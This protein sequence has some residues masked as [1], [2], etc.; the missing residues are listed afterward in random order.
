MSYFL[1]YSEE[2]PHSIKFINYLQEYQLTFFQIV[3]VA[4]AQ[5]LPNYIH[6]VPSI[7]VPNYEQPLVGGQV[8]QWL[9]QFLQQSQQQSQR[10]RPRQR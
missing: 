4:T 9:E 8:F 7:I 2:C 3:N 10:S 1:F 6:S 5:N